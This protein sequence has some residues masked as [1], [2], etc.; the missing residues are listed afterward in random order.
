MAIYSAKY[1]KELVVDSMRLDPNYSSATGVRICAVLKGGKKERMFYVT[2]LLADDGR[3][4][5]QDVIAALKAKIHE[6]AK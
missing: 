4:E 2:D 6:V 1:A 3:Q 5:I